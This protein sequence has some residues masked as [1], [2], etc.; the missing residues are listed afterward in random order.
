[1]SYQRKQID[2]HRAVRKAQYRQRVE[3]RETDYKRKE[4]HP[5]RA[6]LLA[7]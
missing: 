3:K 7:E 6:F 1:M 2:V 5:A 4:K